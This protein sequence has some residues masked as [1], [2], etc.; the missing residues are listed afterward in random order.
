MSSR[1]KPGFGFHQGGSICFSHRYNQPTISFE[2][3]RVDGVRYVSMNAGLKT[4]V[5]INDW[6]SLSREASISVSMDKSADI[7]WEKAEYSLNARLGDYNANLQP[8]K[9]RWALR[10]VYRLSSKLSDAS[11][12]IQ[13]KGDLEYFTIDGFTLDAL[14]SVNNL[15]N[16]M[17]S[18]EAL[19]QIMPVEVK[20]TIIEM[21]LSTAFLL[22]IANTGLCVLAVFGAG[23]FYLVIARLNLQSKHAL[24]KSLTLLALRVSF[25]FCM[26]GLMICLS[27]KFILIVSRG[28]LDFRKM[29]FTPIFKQAE[30][31]LLPDLSPKWDLVG[32]SLR[33]STQVLTWCALLKGSIEL[34]GKT[35]LTRAL[36]GFFLGV[37]L[38]S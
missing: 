12:D 31:I 1:N 28:S 26:P 9:F 29:I 23:G 38:L 8:L 32:G 35:S 25:M 2:T 4:D 34:Q 21:V 14:P 20:P 16:S 17:G 22:Q 19:S 18:T 6:V 13:E 33:V 11:I 15:T 7:P 10:H 3:G 5:E 27:S 30:H 24:Q 36:V 37:L